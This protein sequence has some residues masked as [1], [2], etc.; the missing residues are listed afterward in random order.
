MNRKIYKGEILKNNMDKIQKQI[1]KNQLI[2]MGCWRI[3]ISSQG[4][5]F[6]SLEEAFKDTL[7]LLEEG[8]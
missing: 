3:R 6:E 5:E 4:F 2:I 8:K 7:K 1:L